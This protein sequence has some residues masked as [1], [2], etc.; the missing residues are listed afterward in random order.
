MLFTLLPADFPCEL[1]GFTFLK[2]DCHTFYKSLASIPSHRVFAGN[3]HTKKSV[4]LLYTVANG[5][6]YEAML[7][8]VL[9]SIFHPISQYRIHIHMSHYKTSFSNCKVYHTLTTFYII[10]YISKL[11]IYFY[12]YIYMLYS[13]LLNC[14]FPISIISIS[15]ILFSE[16]AYHII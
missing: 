2:L 11:Q 7:M 6:L 10:I 14:I 15:Q 12:N 4:N 3:G 1:K 5:L 8:P 9:I 13:V 16:A